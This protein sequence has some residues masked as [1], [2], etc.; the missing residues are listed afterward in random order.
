[1]RQTLAA[2]SSGDAAFALVETTLALPQV[3]YEPAIYHDPGDPLPHLDLRKVVWDR[4]VVVEHRA[5][6]LTTEYLELTVL[7]EMGRVYR[8]VHRPTGHDVLWRNDIVRPGGGNNDTGWWLWIGGIEYTLPGDEHG[9]TFAL[10][11]SYQILEDSRDRKALQMQVTEPTTGLVEHIHLSVYP[12]RADFE[13]DIQIHNPGADTAH[14]AHWVN[15]MWVP[16]GRNELTDRTEFIIPT[17]GIVI[18][19]R[20]QKNLGPSPQRWAGNPLR[21]IENWRMGDIMAEELTAGFYSAYSHDEEEG[22]V[23]IFDP[24]VTPGMDMWTYGYHP[25]GITMGSGAPSKGYAEMWG[26]TVR[27]FPHQRRPLAPGASLRWSEW[28]YAYQGTGGLSFAS[29]DMAVHS[30]MDAEGNVLRVSV[31]PS[32]RL[33]DAI[34]E[35]RM[36]GRTVARQ[37]FSAAPDRPWETTIAPG[38]GKG[39]LLRVRERGIELG[40]WHLDRR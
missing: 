29:R 27:R 38:E 39:C 6:V 18:E 13:V 4:V 1:M 31:C 5:V 3:D 9:T 19:E 17:E 30:R 28:M 22:V 25:E 32:R 23:R 26:G 8:M 21:S 2:T 36:D 7:P 35:V 34:L 15:P 24:V 14:F 37:G 20:W 40:R 12:G 10:P 16:G 11:W 33:K